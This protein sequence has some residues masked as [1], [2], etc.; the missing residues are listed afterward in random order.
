MMTTNETARDAPSAARDCF[1]SVD[2][3]TTGPNPGSYAMLSLGACLLLDPEQGFY[4]ELKPDSDRVE[5]D[6]LAVSGLSL[7]EL[8]RTGAE[9]AAAMGQFADWLASWLMMQI[10]HKIA[11]K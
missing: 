4:I 11:L 5:P 2:V 7:A 9:P 8:A 6:A 3:E 1:I 10:S